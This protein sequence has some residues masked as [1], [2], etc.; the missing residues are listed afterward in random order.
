MAP[1]MSAWSL[2]GAWTAIPASLNATRPTTTPAGW[3]STMVDAIVRAVSMRV[4]G[5]SVAAM[6][7]ETSNE[8]ITVPSG[9][10]RATV[11]WGRATASAR[12]TNPATSRAPGSTARHGRRPA[13]GRTPGPPPRKAPARSRRRASIAR[14]T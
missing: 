8:I 1:R 13:P 7:P 10:G 3:R 14:A 4:G 12:T 6:L 5:R 11:A 2:V 9:R